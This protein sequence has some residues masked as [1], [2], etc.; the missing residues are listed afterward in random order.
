MLFH[1]YTSA[2]CPLQG[3]RVLQDLCRKKREPVKL[4]K[5]HH[6]VGPHWYLHI[7][8]LIKMA[9]P[10]LL[11]SFTLQNK[12]S[13]TK[14]S[15]SEYYY[16]VMDNSATLSHSQRGSPALTKIRSSGSTLKS[17]DRT[18]WKQTVSLFS[19][20]IFLLL[21]GLT[22]KN[23]DKR[24]SDNVEEWGVVG[25]HLSGFHY[26]FGGGASNS[27]LSPDSSTMARSSGPSGSTLEPVFSAC[28]WNI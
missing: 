17:F 14:L 28:G 21:L 6:K 20:A 24:Q 5:Q 16:L 13:H 23:T 2:D 3:N 15:A 8:T 18:A 9:L 12:W 25:S 10:M 27:C 19:A 1:F 11:R 22:R 4:F 26:I 7:L